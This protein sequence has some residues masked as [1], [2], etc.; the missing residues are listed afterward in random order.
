MLVQW[1]QLVSSSVL[2][3]TEGPTS[4][5]QMVSSFALETVMGSVMC[6]SADHAENGGEGLPSNLQQFKAQILPIIALNSVIILT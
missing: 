2:G 5:G 4:A 1:R 6:P 3:T